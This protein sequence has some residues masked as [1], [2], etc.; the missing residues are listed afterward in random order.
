MK[1]SKNIESLQ[2]SLASIINDY[3]SDLPV[4]NWSSEKD[5]WQELL[6]CMI[7]QVKP[8]PNMDEVREAT[9]IWEKLN[10]TSPRALSAI[11][12]DDREHSFL[13]MTLMQY[14]FTADEALT[15]V[16]MVI[17]LGKIVSQNYNGKL[18]TCIRKYA[19]ALRDE[20]TK[21]FADVGLD[22]SQI[23]YGVVHWLQNTMNAPLSLSHKSVIAFCREK[24]VTPQELWD[25]ADQLEINLAV[26]DD[27]LERRDFVK[28]FE[29]NPDMENKK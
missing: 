22:N 8:E 19:A 27:V 6:V 24:N 7:N 13:L 5:R 1:Q 4:G 17:A 23:N 20:L 28:S 3:G 2:G 18:Q 10:L 29:V 21:T 12:E 16:N 14:D 11:K 15:A 26:I 25:A 9:E